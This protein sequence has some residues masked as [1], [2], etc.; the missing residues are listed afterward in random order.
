MWFSL[1]KG[2]AEGLGLAFNVESVICV[3]SF[4]YASAAQLGMGDCL[5]SVLL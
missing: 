5:D 2:R 1:A 4:G 3:I